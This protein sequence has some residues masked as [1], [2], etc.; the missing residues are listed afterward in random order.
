MF[1]SEIYS[2][3]VMIGL[4]E[5]AWSVCLRV[6]DVITLYLSIPPI[7]HGRPKTSKLLE[8]H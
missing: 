7:P 6:T 5:Q 4:K 8:N 3:F 2:V 1:K